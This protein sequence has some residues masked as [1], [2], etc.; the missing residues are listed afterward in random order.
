MS[1]PVKR[2][3]SSEALFSDRYSISR[4]LRLSVKRS[5]MASTALT[6][7]AM[8]VVAHVAGGL[9]RGQE[10]KEHAAALVGV[11]GAGFCF[12]PCRSAPGSRPRPRPSRF[13]AHVMIH[14]LV[15]HRAALISLAQ[16]AAVVRAAGQP[17]GG[18]QRMGG[19]G[20]ADIILDVKDVVAAVGLRDGGKVGAKAAHYTA[21]REF[22]RRL[23]SGGAR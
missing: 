7:L 6:L 18:H 14:A 10:V 13:G 20:Q 9:D 19:A 4:R 12:L 17:R 1:W 8:I 16:G 21:F 15:A 3:V 11:K 23:V 22:D 2:V 5:W